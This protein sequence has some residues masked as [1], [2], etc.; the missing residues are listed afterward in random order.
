MDCEN[1][2]NLIL[3]LGVDKFLG[4]NEKKGRERKREEKLLEVFLV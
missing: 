3:K 1:A 2:N 4:E